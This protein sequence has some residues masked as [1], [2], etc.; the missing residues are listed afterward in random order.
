MTPKIWI[1]VHTNVAGCKEYLPMITF[2]VSTVHFGSE[3]ETVESAVWYCEIMKSKMEDAGIKKA[4]IKRKPHKG[5]NCP[6]KK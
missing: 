4:L 1:R 3:C 5:I 2:G 6:I